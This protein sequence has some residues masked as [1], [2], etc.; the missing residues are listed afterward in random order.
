MY[1]YRE[2][3]IMRKIFTNIFLISTLIVIG[4]IIYSCSKV[5]DLIENISVPIPFSVTTN[6]DVTV[7]LVI[8]DTINQVSTPD[9][10]L[11]LDLDAKIK[12]EY[13]SLSVNNL[14]SAKLDLFSIDYVSSTDSTTLD[15]IKN[16]TILI[17]A[18]NLAEVV[19]AESVNNTSTSTI[20]FTPVANLQLLDYLKSTQSSIIL[21]VKGRKTANDIM[22]LKINSSFKLEVGL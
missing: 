4:N 21:K 18:P 6:T 17:K 14:K 19:I 1:V 20:A 16:A 15:V 3:K 5:E 11:N 13:P 22:K 2:N 10:P 7:P 12:A 9:I 8:V